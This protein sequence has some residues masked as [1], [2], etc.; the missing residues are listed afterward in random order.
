MNLHSLAFRLRPS[1]LHH[2]LGLL[3][4]L[5][6]AAS[7]AYYGYYT[8]TEQS[9]FA[10]GLLQEQARAA[11]ETF[12]AAGA[13]ALDEGNYSGMEVLVRHAESFDGLRT[14]AALRENGTPVAIMLRDAN[15]KLVS[16][17]STVA[18]KPPAQ[19]KSRARLEHDGS[20]GGDAQS[21]VAWA[22]INGLEVP[23]WIRIEFDTRAIRDVRGH[24]LA[25]A[26]R[27]GLIAV[28]M[29][30]AAVLLFLRRLLAALRK[31][32]R[33]AEGLDSDYG[34]MTPVTDSSL[35]I[36]QLE[37]ALNWTSIRLFDQ[38]NALRE[39]EKRKGAI[40]EAA[41]DC[42]IT[43]DADG[44][45]IEFN[46]AAERTFGYSRADMLQ[47]HLGDFIIPPRLHDAHEQ[48][49]PR[50]LETGHG[51][52][53]RQRIEITAMRKGGEE[54]PVELAVIPV[55]TGERMMFTAYLRDISETRRVQQALK[56][57]EQRYR[58]VVENLSEIVFQTDAQARWTY[59]NPA[60]TDVTNFSVEESLGRPVLEFAPEEDHP[61]IIA[62]FMPLFERALDST[63]IELRYLTKDR[64]ERW[65]EVFVRALTDASGNLTGFAGSAADVTDRRLAQKQVQDQLNLVQQL[66]EVIPSPI[67]F[68]NRDG[69][70]I[71]VNKAFESFFERARAELI[72]KTASEL[73]TSEQARTHT[74][75]DA[76]LLESRRS[77]GVRNADS[78]CE[79]AAHA[80]ASTRRP[81]SRVRM[82]S[83]PAF[84]V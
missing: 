75:R 1:R 21:I 64:G 71:G 49:M 31:A 46:P 72:G 44:N 61:K 24:I 50:F 84:S 30:T 39:S 19:R 37:N 40:L 69:R 81:C 66:I 12:A 20:P 23:G 29:S 82:A 33:F 6:F 32:T 80:S 70:Y 56:D 42:I 41:L 68:K 15:G 57:S 13:R 9:E 48:G 18:I 63:S 65:C 83:K 22:P 2:Q 38:N 25:D 78:P 36:D 47:Q 59:L 76:E 60:W 52:V 11:A 5:L 35:E 8:A 14:I 51:P 62:A 73:L 3:F 43:V 34:N 79:T 28:V 58:S 10:E 45:V 77:A 53:L 74:G 27:I 55:D 26:L 67:Y 4:A 16:S 54:F 7:I 17:S